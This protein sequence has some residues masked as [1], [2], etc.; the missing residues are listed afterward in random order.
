[1]KEYIE[2]KI[3]EFEERERAIVE[4]KQ[5][6]MKEMLINYGMNK[7][8]AKQDELNNLL[9]RTRKIESKIEDLIHLIVPVL[10]GKARITIEYPPIKYTIKEGGIFYYKHRSRIDLFERYIWRSLD[11]EQVIEALKDQLDDEKQ[12]I[13]DFILRKVIR[14]MKEREGLKTYEI[15][16]GNVRVI[17]EINS[18]HVSIGEQEEIESIGFASYYP[19]CEQI[20]I[21][22][23]IK[24]VLESLDKHYEKIH[25]YLNLLIKTQSE[26]E[27]KAGKYLATV[28][29]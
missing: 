24:E 5:E 19:N 9:E 22:P 7:V 18:L 29:L 20:K 26:I 16:I 6:W 21:L 1:L 11:L 25:S 14:I 3:E 13:L 8:E 12:S 10:V 2:S 27:H 15:T 23:V 4:A 17:S 28:I